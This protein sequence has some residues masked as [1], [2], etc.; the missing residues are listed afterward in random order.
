V[1]TTRFLATALPHSL[2]EEAPFHASV[3]VTHRLVPDG[4]DATL[5]DFPAAADWVATLTTGT[6]RLLAST[7]PAGVPVRTVSKP[8]ATAWAAVFPPDT[9]VEGFRTPDVSDADWLSYPA[10]S[11]G[12]HAL[13]LHHANALASPLDPPGLAENPALEGIWSTYRQLLPGVRELLGPFSSAKAERAA[14][15]LRQKTDAAVATLGGR[16]RRDGATSVALP[17]T[18]AIEI[19]LEHG[20]DDE[21]LTGF[22]D[23]MVDRGERPDDPSL[24]AL[25][26]AHATRRYYQREEPPYRPEPVDGATTPRPDPPVPDVHDRAA[27]FGSTPV[28]LRRLGLVVDV[29]VDDPA[30]RALLARARWIAAELTPAPGVDAVRQAPPR[31]W[32]ESDGTRFQAVSSTAWSGGA[33]PLGDPDRYVVLDLDPDA[34]GL[35][36]EQH[37]RTLPRTLASELNGDRA[38]G[39][40]ASLRATGFSVARVDRVD[41][42]RAQVARA[43]GFEAV[44]DAEGVHGP[45]L[46]YDDLV[47]GIRVE[48]WDDRT[49]R[50]HSL[51]ERRVD[52]TAGGTPVLTDAP[53]VGFL[54]LSGLNSQPGDTSTYYLHQV[55]AGW[56]GWS[57]SAPRP[58]KVIVHG[59]GVNGPAGE[60]LVLDEPPDDPHTHVHI[61]SRVEP[62]TLPWLR[63]GWEYSFRIRGVD[64]AGNAVP[65]PPPPDD[66]DAAVTTAATRQLALLRRTYAARDAAGFL[67]G[68]RAA[69]LA[70]LP[71]PDPG[72]SL[73]DLLAGV[74]DQISRG[75]ERAAKEAHL[76]SARRA[77]ELPAAARTG[78]KAV[79]DVLR[80]RLAA[81]ADAR[82]RSAAQVERDAVTAAVATLART[83]E[84]WRTRPNLEVDPARFARAIDRVGSGRLRPGAIKVP[85]VEL[86]RPTP[87]SPATAPVVTTPRPFLRWSPVPPPT[88]V[89]VHEYQVGESAHRLV[90]RHGQPS[91]RHVVPPKTS[92]LEAE[93]H[94]RFDGVIGSPS[95]D[96]HATLYP[97][98]LKERGTLQDEWVP[99]TTDANVPVQQPGIEL[100]AR[101][102]ADPAG[103]VTLADITADRETQLGEGQ[104]VLH[105]TPRLRV[106]YLPDPLAVGVALVFHDA[107][108]PHVLP[109]PRVL[110]TVVLPYDLDEDWPDLVPLRLVA[111]PGPTL[112]ARREGH[113][114]HV[115]V[116]P[117]EQVRVAMSSSLS[118]DDLD[119]LGMWRT[120]LAS[121]PGADPAAKAVLAHA[122]ASGWCW[123]LTPSID[124]RLVHAVPRPVRPPEIE[125]L[126]VVVRPPGLPV[127]ALAGVVDVHGASTERL[128]VE[129]S[130][131]E[132]VDDL[133]ADAPRRLARHD[134]VTSS[135]VQVDERFGLLHIFDAVVPGAPGGEPVVSHRAIQTFEDTHHRRVT[136]AARGVTRYAEFFEPAELPADDD[137][138]LRGAPVELTVASSA[139]PAAPEVTDVLPLLAWDEEVEPDHPFALRRRRRSGVRIWLD[140]PWY[141]SGDGELLGV[142]IGGGDVPPSSSSAWA[143]DPILVT[144]TPPATRVLPLVTAAELV[145]E[146]IA[147]EVVDEQPDRP[148]LPPTQLG[149]VDLAGA[150]TATV[151]G[152]RP[153][154]H[155]GRRQ[156]FVDVAM[157]PGKAVWPFVRLA[158]AR[159]QPDSIA[160]CHL[161]PVVMTDWAQP[162]PE[163]TL[164]VSRPSIQGV[165]VTLTGHIAL[166][167]FPR[168]GSVTTPELDHDAVLALSREVF[169]TVQT[170]PGGEATGDLA[171][172]DLVRVRV[173]LAGLD[174]ETQLVTW[175]AEVPLD[176]LDEPVEVVTP[177]SSTTVRV[178]VEE[179][180]H[181]DADPD[182]GPKTGAPGVADR[183]VYADAIAL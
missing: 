44:D 165:R 58:G 60:E 179:V 164:T 13:Q 78:V 142:V 156:W 110:Q 28:L 152:Y 131:E 63:F 154:Y 118:L 157:D 143:K 107:G 75:Q 9:P 26:D 178:L 153:D 32:C 64:L 57:L 182:E 42:T 35:K 113:V 87:G 27:S 82:G 141:S 5:A 81:Q 23:G 117:G 83:Q 128:I 4:P 37:L 121:Q 68:A 2:A 98:A 18:S 125:A 109:E 59:D 16:G 47:R 69:L 40:P 1:T 124:V 11:V 122:A 127:A 167:R 84:A 70:R 17:W 129:A 100:A 108:D 88:L 86:P 104:Y 76:P 181:L 158:V 72:R 119:V 24:R 99:S 103:L 21:R 39:S 163:R 80:A 123:W 175:S 146:L 180:E 54:Q 93:Q 92:Q 176:D 145:R 135:P 22:L 38:S 136:Y 132:W 155:P 162:L 120:H 183:V 177:G 43:E 45:D 114:V 148:V 30:D 144:G 150:P 36:L 105:D 85:G 171:W 111:E 10:D 173:P 89:P 97:T 48:V 95:P 62:G 130:W 96:V 160:G 46:I 149:L 29:A 169:A 106:P 172:E 8:S 170:R 134:V 168:R 174:T 79:D 71:E 133:S 61:R 90:I 15:L 49:G 115:S 112:G 51:H 102:G 53:D 14:T 67:A 20:D 151:V 34:S 41:A 6:L 138:T 55:L 31:T 74:S 52:V 3:F 126:K 56:D 66:D 77:A 91:E 19:L 25:V 50:W 161:S 140:R 65:L 33:L 147:D 137:P 94:G 159:Y 116:P 12:E 139:R 73:V 7:A 166:S 101:P